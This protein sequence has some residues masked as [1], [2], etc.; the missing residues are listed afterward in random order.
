M[1][2][3]IFS[4]GIS[5][6]AAMMMKKIAAHFK[7][8]DKPAGERKR[9]EKPVPLLGG[10]APF[11]AFF[12]AV[13]ALYFAGQIP[14]NL[15][16]PIGGLFIASSIIMAGGFLGDKIFLAPKYQL[17]APFLAITIAVVSG[18]RVHL[19]TNPAGGVIQL[20]AIASIP[21]SFF[22]L[23]FI[24]YATKIL[25]GL[26]GLV[27]GTT[28]L[29]AGAIFLFTTFSEFK[30][31]SLAN[32]ALALAGAF[33]GFLLLNFPRAKIYLGEG[34]SI[35]AGF[36]LGSLAIITGAKIAVTLMVLALPI[37]DLVAVMIKRAMKS[38]SIFSGD[39]LHLHYWLVDKGWKPQWAAAVFWTVSAVLGVIS[40]FLPPSLKPIVLAAIFGALFLADIFLFVD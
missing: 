20:A 8:V 16:I 24:S 17:I 19:I 23:F 10:V 26:D 29:G 37:I 11:A 2:I 21:L 28:V 22:W 31:L 4:A 27:G 38:K 18:V 7:I 6:V 33:F 14:A 34:G 1:F 39:R 13:A 32:L 36:I 25:D 35:F 3:F 9:H 40:I 12:I 5:F 15:I 30:E